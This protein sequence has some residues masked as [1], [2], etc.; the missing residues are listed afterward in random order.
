[1]TISTLKKRQWV[2]LQYILLVSSDVIGKMA[3][4]L[5][6]LTKIT[7]VI[8]AKA[9]QHIAE[10][11]KPYL[12]VFNLQLFEIKKLSHVINTLPLLTVGFYASLSEAPDADRTQCGELKRP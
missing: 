11:V 2:L 3:W 10:V 7:R 1:M 8:T 12:S 5:R 4:M 9:K 6:K